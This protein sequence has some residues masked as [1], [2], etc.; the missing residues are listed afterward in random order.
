MAKIVS[1]SNY[2]KLLIELK[3]KISSAQVKTIRTV[4]SNLIHLYLDIGGFII[5][6][7][8]EKNWGDKV[9]ENLSKDLNKSFPDMQ[10]FSTR[11]LKYMK[12]FAQTWGS[13]KIGQQ[14]VAQLPWGHNILLM[15]QLDDEQSRV[16]YAKKCVENNWSRS[17]LS[18]QIETGLKEKLGSK[19]KTNNFKNTLSIRQSDLVQNTL[20]DPY[21]FDFLTIGEQAREREIEKALIEHIQK[22]LLELGAG[23]AFIG[24]QVPISVGDQDYFL[25]LLF[26]HARL[27]CYVVIELKATEFR[28]EH[29]GQLNFYLS[30]VDAQIKTELDQ[31]TIGLLLCQKKNRIVAEYALKNMSKPMGIAEYKLNKGIPNNI[32]SELPT[33]KELEQ[34]L[35]KKIAIKI[36]KR[37]RK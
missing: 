29:T 23:F 32:K 37:N 10:G 22:F 27:H 14:L 36:K 33:I 35:S 11:N 1:K 13:T 19:S 25:D 18:I 3:D 24:R 21:N 2:K 5:K 28:P 12:A 30:A 26:Y 17:I 9:I 4:N 34:E 8:N 20:K 15:T 16:W 7:L 31:P 6:N